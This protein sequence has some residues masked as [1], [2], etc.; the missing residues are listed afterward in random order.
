[1]TLTENE[2]LSCVEAGNPSHAI[3][4]AFATD[5]KKNKIIILKDKNTFYRRKKKKNKTKK[6]FAFT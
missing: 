6:P 1:M 2:I 3:L 4:T 5:F